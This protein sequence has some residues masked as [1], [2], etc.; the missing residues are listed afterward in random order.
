MAA[1]WDSGG[2]DAGGDRIRFSE[3]SASATA[4]AHDIDPDAANYAAGNDPD[5][6]YRNQ[7]RADSPNGWGSQAKADGY[8][9]GGE[10]D[11]G[12]YADGAAEDEQPHEDR[13]DNGAPDLWGDTDPDA[14]IYAELDSYAAGNPDRQQDSNREDKPEASPDADQRGQDQPAQENAEQTASPEQQQF[15]ALKAEN[16]SVKQGLANANQQIADLKATRDE[17]ATR[18]DH[19]EQFLADSKK[20]PADSSAADHGGDKIATSADH[21]KTQDAASAE[22]G[23]AMAEREAS[24][25]RKDAKEAER[26]RWRRVTSSE[27]LGLIGTLGGAAQTVGEFAVHA[28]PEGMLGLGL[29]ALGVAQVLRARAE[30]KAESKGKGQA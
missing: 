29:T 28:S 4:D 1:E 12:G 8:P 24:H 18:I 10:H 27:S 19:I 15:N 30:K 21:Q 13:Y 20:N 14:A 6:A 23:R 7:G 16:A 2:S 26:S 9:D 5:I 17:Q 22:R 25:E 11:P 3:T